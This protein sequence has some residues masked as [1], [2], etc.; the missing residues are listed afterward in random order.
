MILQSPLSPG[1][2]SEELMAR[3]AEGAHVDV[4]FPETKDVKD[5]TMLSY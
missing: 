5:F 4:Y 3:F 2:A 1:L